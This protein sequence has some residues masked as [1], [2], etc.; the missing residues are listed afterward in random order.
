M[1]A[2]PPYNGDSCELFDVLK[3]FFMWD[4]GRVGKMNSESSELVLSFSCGSFFGVGHRELNCDFG[5]HVGT[6]EG[7]PGT[8]RRI[9]RK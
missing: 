7:F 4:V 6:E 8:V 3:Y 1:T 9:P 2:A 5:W